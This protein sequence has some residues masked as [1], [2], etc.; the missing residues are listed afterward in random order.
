M[1]KYIC[2]CASVQI[3]KVC[4]LLGSRESIRGPGHAAQTQVIE[5]IE[6]EELL[7]VGAHVWL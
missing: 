6:G 4:V 1:H 5:G 2:L 3:V 7:E